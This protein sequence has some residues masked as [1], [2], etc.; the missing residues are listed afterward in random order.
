MISLPLQIPLLRIGSNQV[1]NYEPVWL[2]ETIN[3]A[4]EKAGHEGWWFAEDIAQSIFLYLQDH[5]TNST[6]ELE[7]IDEKIRRILNALGF[8]DIAEQVKL[9][10]P[11][12]GISLFEI[13][14]E[15]GTGFELAFYS[16]L[17]KRIRE[18]VEECQIEKFHFYSLRDGIKFLHG[19]RLWTRS[20]REFADDTIAFIRERLNSIANDRQVAFLL[21]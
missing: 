4:A 5:C 14:T 2:E 18:A 1:V 16:L 17:D 10:P 8:C 6:I 11:P 13:A 21:N 3:V 19:A 20:C 15:A 7:E 9:E 12:L